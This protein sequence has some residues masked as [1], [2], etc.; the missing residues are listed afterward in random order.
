MLV[1]FGGTAELRPADL[2]LRE[3]SA[4]E[5]LVKRDST[6][7]MAR[8][9]ASDQR[10]LWHPYASTTTPTPVHLVRG[11]EGTM[12]DLEWPGTDGLPRRE[13]VVDAMASWWC[14]VH[15]Y[16]HPVIVE[17]V[18]RQAEA[19]PHVM[20]GGLTHEPAIALAQV[21]AELAPGE[22]NR[23][24]L[25]DS[26]SVSV[27]VALKMARQYDIAVAR[28]QGG[29]RSPRTRIAALRGAYHGDTL[30]AMS[31]CDPVT[32]MHAM[33]AG[34]IPPQLFLRRPPVW[35]AS[36]GEVNAWVDEITAQLREARD[37]VC[38]VIVEPILQGAGGMYAWV[39]TALAALRRITRELGMLLIA[40]EIATGFGRTGE[41][42]GCDH[43]GVVP[44]IM[45]V[46]KS[47]TGGSLTQAAVIATEEVARTV[48]QYTGALMHGPTFMGNPLACA[49][50][51]A[52]IGLLLDAG[53]RGQVAGVSAAFTEHGRGLA[54][55]PGVHDFR[56]CGASAALEFDDDV[57]IA[58]A[59]RIGL[60]HGVWFRPFGRLVYSLPPYVCTDDEIARIC[61]AMAAIAAQMG[62][63]G[64]GESSRQVPQVDTR[65][66][67]DADTQSRKG[68]RA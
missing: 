40:D 45:T 52:S 63:R 62:H 3:S 6:R 44:D 19:L 60:D 37:D 8:L 31:V 61:A 27:E 36:P 41:L 67:K 51:L 23:V 16:R 10:H 18:R 12:L 33:Y 43:A 65:I 30:G 4:R 22:L 28:R 5:L 38:A 24:F 11:A 57:D 59:T 20:F 53:W 50:S 56:V 32:G 55:L 66:R 48:S 54:Q 58:T 39:P 9:L 35:D 42:W 46:G 1:T 68:G 13:R 21:L 26:G 7:P 2:A 17:A 29:V 34:A 47:M 64:Q 15:G 14:M 49:A 25:A